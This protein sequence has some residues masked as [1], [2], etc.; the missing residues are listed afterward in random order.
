MM[1]L[2][3]VERWNTSITT[4]DRYMVVYAVMFAPNYRKYPLGIKNPA[5]L[6]N[7]HEYGSYVTPSN[8][9]KDS[10]PWCAFLLP[11]GYAI[12]LGGVKARVGCF[13]PRSFGF[14]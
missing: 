5:C 9:G 13:R 8:L 12:G 10:V 4:D 7:I 6:N 3:D 14:R 11:A 1:T 2:D